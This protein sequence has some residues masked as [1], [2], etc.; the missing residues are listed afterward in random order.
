MLPHY[1]ANRRTVLKHAAENL[2]SPTDPLRAFWNDLP[3][4]EESVARRQRPERAGGR[5]DW[6]R[7]EPIGA[8]A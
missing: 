4:L 1:S 8:G 3:R 7:R 6:R 2:S 5:N